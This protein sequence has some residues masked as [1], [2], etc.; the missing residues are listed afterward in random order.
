MWPNPPWGTYEGGRMK[1][2]IQVIGALLLLGAV[3][4][5]ANDIEVKWA[6]PSGQGAMIFWNPNTGNTNLMLNTNGTVTAGAITAAGYDTNGVMTASSINCTGTVAVGATLAVT[7]KTTLTGGLGTGN[8]IVTNTFA[9]GT[10][11]QRIYYATGNVMT[12]MTILP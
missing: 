3:A 10:Y 11:T 2:A 5:F 7:G 12:N 8:V 9:G 1:K 4:G 6:G